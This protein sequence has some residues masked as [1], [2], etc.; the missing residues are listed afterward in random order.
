MNAARKSERPPKRGASASATFAI[1]Q[2]ITTVMTRP[3][4][5]CAMPARIGIRTVKPIAPK[6]ISEKPTKVAIA[7]I[8]ASQTSQSRTI[9]G[10]VVASASMRG[11][12]VL[13]VVRMALMRSIDTMEG[14]PSS[15][16][17]D[18]DVRASGIVST[19]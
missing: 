1:S 12:S 5:A 16:H 4:I 18:R 11:H 2:V 7:G 8:A 10:T 6:P 15:P 14:S 17:A 19:A 9:D 3:T 13:G